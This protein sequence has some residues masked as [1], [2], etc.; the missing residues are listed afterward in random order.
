MK[1]NTDKTDFC[2]FTRNPDHK[3]PTVRMKD[4]V[5]KSVEKVKVLVVIRD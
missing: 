2:L 3:T 4:K 1:E 5:P